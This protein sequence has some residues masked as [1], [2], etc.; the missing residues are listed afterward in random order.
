MSPRSIVSPL[1]WGL[2]ALVACAIPGTLGAM[3]IGSP[4]GFLALNSSFSIAIGL[5]LC[6]PRAAWV[7]IAIGAAAAGVAANLTSPHVFPLRELLLPAVGTPLL[8]L[9]S[10]WLVT[11][12]CAGPPEL[13]RPRHAAMMLASLAVVGGGLSI[14]LDLVLARLIV[15]RFALASPWVIV[16]IRHTVCLLI[17]APSILA[18]AEVLRHG[19]SRTPKQLMIRGLLVSLTIAA[20]LQAFTGEPNDWRAFALLLLPVGTIVATAFLSGPRLATFNALLMGIG[21]IGLTGQGQ[22][23]IA[24]LLS[25]GDAVVGVDLFVICTATLGLLTAAAVADRAR[26]ATD[27]AKVR[28]RLELAVIGSH[29]GIWDWDVLKDHT[30][31]AGVTTADG[32]PGWPHDRI[33]WEEALHAD[34]RHRVHEALDAHLRDGHPYSVDYRLL[35]NR[36]EY[37]WFRSRGEAIRDKSGGAIRMLGTV[38]DV[39]DE[40][41]ATQQLAESEERFRLLAEVS[42]DFITRTDMTGR[43]VYRSPSVL[44]TFGF[45]PEELASTAP[46]TRVHPDDHS[47]LQDIRDAVMRGEARDA[48]FRAFTADGSMIW[49]DMRSRPLFDANG[50]QIGA[51]SY[52]HDITSL[53]EAQNKMRRAEDRYRAFITQSSEA[54]WRFDMD[55]PVDVS[56]PIDAVSA[57]M[58]RSARLAECNDAMAVMCGHDCAANF[59]GTR[60]DTLMPP[61]DPGTSRCLRALIAAGFRLTDHEVIAS[62]HAGETR[63]M[64]KN[65]VGVIENGCLMHVWGTQRDVTERRRAEQALADAEAQL[66]AIFELASV[67][68]AKVDL[69]GRFVL[70]NPGLCRLLGRTEAELVSGLTFMDVTHPADRAENTRIRDHALHAGTDRYGMR[71]RYLR[72]DGTIVWAEL[73]ATIVRDA[74]GTPLYQI[75]VVTDITD[76]MRAEAALAASESKYRQLVEGLNVVAWEG[77]AGTFDFAFVSGAAEAILGYTPSEWLA[78]GFWL[79]I[80]HPD[81]RDAAMSYCVNKTREGLDHDFEYRAIHKDGR[82]VWLRDLVSVARDDDGTLRLRGVLIDITQ[83][84]RDELALRESERTNRAILAA[85]PDVMFVIDPSGRY[86]DYHAQDTA[87]LLVPP[88]QFLGRTPTEVL[89]RHLAQLHEDSIQRLRQTGQAQT[90]D[91]RIERRG[92]TR[93]WEVRMVLRDDGCVIS[94]VRNITERKRA[95]QALAESQRRLAALVSQAPVGIIVWNTRFEIVQWNP[96]A[97]RMFGYAAHEAVGKHGGFIVPPEARPIVDDVWRSLISGRGGWHSINDNITRGGARITCE[98]NNTPFVGADGAVIGVSSFVQDVTERVSAERRQHLLMQELDHRVKNNMAAVLSLAEQTGRAAESLDDFQTTFAGRVRALARM[99]N[100]LAANRWRVCDLAALVRQTVG[101]YT[102]ESAARLRYAG[103]DA[104]VPA[105]AAQSLA[106]SLNELATNAAKHGS[107]TTA[108]GAVDIR[109]SVVPPTAEQPPVLLLQWLERGGP[110]AAPPTRRGLGMDLIEGAIIYQLGGKVEFRFTPDG[111]EC[112]LTVPF[113]DDEPG[114]GTSPGPDNQALAAMERHP[115]SG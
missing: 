41:Q 64:I 37:R 81:D 99:H 97:E 87:I 28:E 95:E 69:D 91:Y 55:P 67:G 48:Q 35:V 75:S 92:D 20:T 23:P 100:V 108:D 83:H 43:R 3:H 104:A 76:R 111:L 56:Q 46:T 82:V 34:D 93:W 4:W 94:L 14:A 90:Y 86:V 39:T 32:R 19:A 58:L 45:T 12:L 73:A 106:I 113:K 27:A 85:M 13:S 36:D 66:R 107:L 52:G 47:L 22:G 9:A 102:G 61:N 65:M 44:T 10:A 70:V 98:W 62:N 96:A 51:V 17:I 115:S 53:R 71:K 16:W 33:T 78:P 114:N 24:A 88:E 79:R 42:D 112:D 50:V 29:V 25:R 109:W 57:A 84:R 38:V 59:V 31:W 15:G 101:S 49:V 105:R 89:P 7:A 26:L 2:G 5:M 6:A 18:L 8:L 77:I 30:V 40:M 74:L 63:V 1:L 103:P 110:A 68:M 72:P 54:M 60:L 11:R 21:A 80:I